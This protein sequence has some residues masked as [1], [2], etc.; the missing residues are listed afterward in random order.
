MKGRLR[1]WHMQDSDDI[2]RNQFLDLFLFLL[3]DLDDHLL[4]AAEALLDRRAVAARG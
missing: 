1:K 2:D 3:G 4:V